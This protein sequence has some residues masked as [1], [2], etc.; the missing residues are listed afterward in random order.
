MKQPIIHV[1]LPLKRKVQRYHVRFSSIYE[2]IPFS[3]NDPNSDNSNALCKL[4]LYYSRRELNEIRRN[5]CYIGRSIII[6]K[7]QSSLSP[8]M[9]KNI[10][11]PDNAQDKNRYKPTLAISDDTRGL[12]WY[13]C[14][15]WRRRQRHTN[16]ILRRVAL[17]CSIYNQDQVRR[18][19]SLS[20]RLTAWATSIAIDEGYR[21]FYRAHD[22]PID[23]FLS[24]SSSSLLVD[25]FEF[26]R[27]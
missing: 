5:A 25:S 12:E 7:R 11:M 4:S 2:T 17:P 14:K 22:I 6:G 26:W 19:A 3:P 24:A 10:G 27:N 23:D 18:L 9:S 21:D 1:N 16:E 13:F 8:T 15:E 20:K